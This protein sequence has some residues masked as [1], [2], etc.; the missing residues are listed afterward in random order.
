MKSGVRRFNPFLPVASGLYRIGLAAYDRWPRRSWR[1]DLP[2]VGVGNL[3]WGG[4]GKT[5]LVA[6]LA[7]LF[8]SWG[9]RPAVVTWGYGGRGPS[10][11][12]RDKEGGL[13]PVEEVGDES[14][15]LA[16]DL[17]V[18]VY[19]GRSRLSLLRSLAPRGERGPVLIDDAF[20]DRGYRPAVQIL[21]V[22]A[23]DPLGNG[24]LL[25]WGSLREPPDAA[26]RAD[27]AVLMRVDLIPDA[28]NVLDLVHRMTGGG[29]VVTARVASREL[30]T[31]EGTRSPET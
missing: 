5:S 8:L 19:A 12:V 20:Q 3:T 30:L 25:P 14:R 17:G 23:T 18:P 28:G 4:A 26:R 2:L 1:P 16:E 13:R 15:M 21:V 9:A 24:H 11:P 6:T 10:G 31:P 27:L 22:D 7:R 29:P